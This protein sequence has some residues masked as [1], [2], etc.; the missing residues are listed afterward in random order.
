MRLA[1]RAWYDPTEGSAR[2]YAQLG[3]AYDSTQY[4]AR[5]E[6]LRDKARPRAVRPSANEKEEY[7]HPSLWAIGTVLR[8]RGT[9]HAS[10]AFATKVRPAHDRGWYGLMLHAQ[11]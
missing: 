9:A 11:G 3:P 7:K 10:T 6:Y 8:L 2:R 4:H 5:V 1:A